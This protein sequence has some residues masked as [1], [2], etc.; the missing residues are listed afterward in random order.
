MGRLFEGGLD[1]YGTK[2]QQALDR[3]ELRRRVNKTGRYLTVHGGDPICGKK[4]AAAADWC[5]RERNLDVAF[6]DCREISF[7]SQ[8]LHRNWRMDSFSAGTLRF[9]S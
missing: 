7:L 6:D 5:M 2:A 1:Y 8:S 9:S 4:P 3:A